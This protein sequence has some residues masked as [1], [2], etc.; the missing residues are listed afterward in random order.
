MQAPPE[1]PQFADVPK[2]ESIVN[3]ASFE[4]LKATVLEKEV[5]VHPE[6]QTR[7]D[8]D[9]VVSAIKDVEAA[10]ELGATREELRDKI[11]AVTRSEGIREAV[12][13]LV[14]KVRPDI[15]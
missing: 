1:A 4:D 7:I 3:A 15:Q 11:K 14:L 12:I 9:T 5:L 8:V 13:Q 10:I 6:K 2:S